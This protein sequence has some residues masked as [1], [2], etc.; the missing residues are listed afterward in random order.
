MSDSLHT[1]G[2]T[3]RLLK[4]DITGL[5]VEAF[6]Y[7]A[8]HNLNLGSGFGTAISTR[9]GLKIQEELKQFGTLETTAAVTTEAGML[10]AKYIIHAVGP[11]FKESNMEK[12]LEKTIVN[13]LKQAEEKNIKQLAFPPMGTGFYGVPL[14]MCA[15]VMFNTIT[16]YLNGETQIEEVIVGLLDSREY[17]PFKQQLNASIAA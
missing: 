11:R 6:V 2:K 5:E 4:G 7:Y 9:G 10:K 13:S 17:E 3:I 8:Q 14:N 12:K 16:K 15:R 1:N